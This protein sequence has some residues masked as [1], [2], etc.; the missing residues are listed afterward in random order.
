LKPTAP[1]STRPP[2]TPSMDTGAWFMK[3]E[4]PVWVAE[5]PDVVDEPVELPPS[6]DELLS[7][8]L[9][10]EVGEPEPV[11]EVVEG[12]LPLEAGP[13]T[14]VTEVELLVET[15]EVELRVPVALEIELLLKR[16]VDTVPVVSMREL[17]LIDAGGTSVDPDVISVVDGNSELDDWPCTVI[18]RARKT[19]DNKDNFIV[20]DRENKN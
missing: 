19:L 20:G 7:V 9:E 17:V 18:M 6:L 12:E 11:L 14:V 10:V 3:A 15:K 1:A 2:M 5:P 4:L 13:E 8:S 16:L